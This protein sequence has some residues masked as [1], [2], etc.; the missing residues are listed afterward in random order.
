MI[1][2]LVNKTSDLPFRTKGIAFR[3]SLPLSVINESGLAAPIFFVENSLVRKLFSLKTQ[4]MKS[5]W[6][7]KLF[8]GI[9]FRQK[10][11]PSK[12]QFAESF[13]DQND[14]R[15]KNFSKNKI[16]A[17]LAPNVLEN[18][19]SFGS[20]FGAKSWMIG[21]N[22]I[23]LRR[24]LVYIFQIQPVPDYNSSKT[25]LAAIIMFAE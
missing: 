1:K 4:K 25:R 11:F 15:R 10:F 13:L 7:E 16:G 3:I 23:L 6:S 5:S 18:V 17:G 21:S 24:I 22:Q 8:N 19:P 12:I 20:E 14:F 2:V 9:I